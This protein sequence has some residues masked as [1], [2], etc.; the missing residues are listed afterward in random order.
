MKS[1][2]YSTYVDYVIRPSYTMHNAMG[3]LRK[4]MSGE[5]LDAPMPFR[6]FFSGRILWDEGMAHAAH[7]YLV[8]H[9]DTLLVGLV[10]ADHVKFQLGIPGRF[11]RL[12]KDQMLCVTGMLNPTLIDSRPA[13]T[14]GMEGSVSNT[15]DQITLQLRVQS[16]RQS[17][18]NPD[19]SLLVD[20]IGSN[21]L[22][23]S[24][25]ILVG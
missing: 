24:N 7:K 12:A 5:L 3:L 15:P 23:I 19:V 21:V 1:P 16:S 9:P 18:V 10:G 4:T 17:A 11:A 2:E 14:V 13:G 22:P 25:Y 6:N 20:S 8:N